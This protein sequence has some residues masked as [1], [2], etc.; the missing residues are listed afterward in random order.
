[1][2]CRLLPPHYCLHRRKRCRPS[3]RYSYSAPC[4]SWSLPFPTRGWTRVFAPTV[5]FQNFFL[6]ILHTSMRYPAQ[7]M[8][9]LSL[10]K[11]HK[12]TGRFYILSQPF[13]QAKNGNELVF[14]TTKN[15]AKKPKTYFASQDK[16]PTADQLGSNTRSVQTAGR[17][18]VYPCSQNRSPSATMTHN[19][20]V[21]A[22]V[23]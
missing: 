12:N 10:L 22:P 16:P 14:D 1:M 20:R 15:A 13:W 6:V 4:R 8:S 2:K 23:G 18:G 19:P 5:P 17:I 11:M 7:H 9:L 3:V 21:S